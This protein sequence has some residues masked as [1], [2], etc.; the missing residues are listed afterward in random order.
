[1][2]TFKRTDANIN[3]IIMDN[4]IVPQFLTLK[5]GCDT[6]SVQGNKVNIS[7]YLTLN[8][9]DNPTYP[10][11][12]DISVCNNNNI[13]RPKR[14]RWDSNSLNIFISEA[15][16]VHGNNFDYSHIT[17]SDIKGSKSKL[18][19]IC[20]KCSYQLTQTISDHISG[21]YGCI[22]CAGKL[23]W[24]LDRFIERAHQVHGDKYD[25][26][27]IGEYHIKGVKSLI[28]LICKQCFYEWET[29]IGGH[30]NGKYGC[31]NCSGNAPWTL[32]RFLSKG[33]ELYGDNYDYSEI[34]EEH[35]RGK[36][37]RIYIKCK[38]CMYG[39]ETTIHS[40][41][42]GNHGCPNCAGIVTWN[43]ERFLIRSHQVHGDKYDYSNVTSDI[44]VN[45]HSK[46][47]LKCKICFYRWSPTITDHINAQSGCPDCSKQ[48]PWNYDKLLSRGKDLYGD[49]YS[50]PTINAEMIKGKYSLIDVQCNHCSYNWKAT[51][52]N[53]IHG[54]HG[55]PRCVKVEPWT[56]ESFISKAVQIHNDK[57]DYSK[58]TSQN[59][60]GAQSKIPLTCKTC[61]HEWTPS[62]HDHINHKSGCPKCNFSKGELACM[63][64]LD[65]LNIRYESQYVI[66]D[67]PNRRYDVFFSHNG[68]NYVLEFDGMQH[69]EECGFFNK[70]KDLIYRQRVD[71]IKTYTAIKLNYNVIRI[72]YSQINNVD[73]H[74]TKALN[75]E[76]KLYVSNP[77]LYQYI[78]QAI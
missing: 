1:M 76:T 46:I 36:D 23:K 44:I 30:I 78:L 62:I 37:S 59:I 73:I 74:I 24:T 12:Q 49:R 17:P 41:I 72:D 19:I 42:N 14:I 67:L 25:Y 6:D 33:V 50:Y 29:S 9:I 31:P 32:K 3:L 68:K 4:K 70:G 75:A 53:H 40:H 65:S 52:Q 69:F 57:Y 56:L 54:K 77:E 21:K 7:N 35:I 20:N 22:S 28:P 43:L 8:V 11:K 45:A 18:P 64:F 71:I 39:W 27:M 5:I 47:P 48:S 26:S 55:C 10:S 58:V 66:H 15:R 61:S 34:H 63:K 51:I 16:R 2:I 13:I 60:K 38:K